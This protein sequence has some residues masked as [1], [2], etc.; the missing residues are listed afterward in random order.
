MKEICI[1]KETVLAV[2][3]MGGEFL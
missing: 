3:E 1:Y 2:S